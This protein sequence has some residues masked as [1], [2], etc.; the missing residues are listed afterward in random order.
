MEWRFARSLQQSYQC[1]NRLLSL[2]S[3]CLPLHWGALSR[4]RWWHRHWLLSLPQWRT[5]WHSR[6]NWESLAKSAADQT[7]GTDIRCL[8]VTNPFSA[9]YSRLWTPPLEQVRGLYRKES[10]IAKL[11]SIC[12]F[13]GCLDQANRLHATSGACSRLRKFAPFSLVLCLFATASLKVE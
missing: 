9:P 5:W 12:V 10:H 2:L 1:Q 7:S 13:Q 4:H 6:S 3:S 8:R 11:A